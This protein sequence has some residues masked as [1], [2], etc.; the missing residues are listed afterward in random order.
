MKI[1]VTLMTE[2]DKHLDE[3]YTKEQ[4]EE[5]TKRAWD[6]LLSMLNQDPSENAFVESCELIER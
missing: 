6:L 3:K 5:M 4:I 1:R 2:N